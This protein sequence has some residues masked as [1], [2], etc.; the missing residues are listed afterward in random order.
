MSPLIPLAVLVAGSL[1]ALARYGVT[2]A[3]A[4]AKHFPWAVL[5]VNVIGC[6]IGGT[7]LALVHVAGISPEWYTVVVTGFAGGLTTFSTW[8]VQTI[9]LLSS[10]RWREAALS[11][12]LNLVV[13]LGAVFAAFGLVTALV[14]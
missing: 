6:A 7:L 9:Q 5:V 10:G 14:G 11:I 13:G 2:Q 3:F 8:S 1:G 12:A 4:G